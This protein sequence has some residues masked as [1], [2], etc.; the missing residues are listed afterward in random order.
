MTVFKTEPTEVEVTYS[1]Y[2]SFLQTNQIE[3]ATVRKSELT[4]FDFHGKLKSQQRVTRT[5]RDIPVTHFVLTLPILDSSVIKEWNDRGVDFSV[6]NEDNTWLSAL[7]S[8]PP[9]CS[10]LCLAHHH[11]QDAGRRTEGDILLREEPREDAE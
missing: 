9:G 11:A 2:Q 6:E 8:A 5:G 7:L 1:E 10:C 3:R 4:N